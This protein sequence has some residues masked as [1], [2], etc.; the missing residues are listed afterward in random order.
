MP[1]LPAL[2]EDPHSLRLLDGGAEAFPRMLAAITGARQSVHLEVYTFRLDAT[3]RRFL[4]ALL[5]A[6]RRGVAVS[7]VIDGWGSNCSS[8][9]IARAVRLAGGEVRI[10]HGL[11]A[12]LRGRLVRNHRKVLLVDDEVAFIGGLNIADEYGPHARGAPW[13]DLELEI[14]GPACASLGR[15]LRGEHELQGGGSVRIHLSGPGGGRKLSKRYL[16]AFGRA[17]RRILLAQAYFLP[18]RHLIRSLTAAARRGVEVRLLLSGRS[19]I[20]LI[21]AATARLYR[22]LLRAGVHVHEWQRSVFHVKAGAVDGTRLLVGSFNLDPLSLINL[23]SLV[24]ADDPVAARQLESWIDSQLALAPE[25]RLRKSRGLPTWAR[26]ILGRMLVALGFWI[27]RAFGWL[28]RP[29]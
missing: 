16:K 11:A 12:F 1:A 29:S 22:R 4:D 17:R 5:S 3:G 21:R 25:V 19:D 8:L 7:V 27:P 18:D 9:A 24:E 10:Y 23:E 20:P 26:A 15:R 14:R 28:R 6:L 2:V 13:L